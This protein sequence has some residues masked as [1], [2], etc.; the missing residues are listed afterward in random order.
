[1]KKIGIYCAYFLP[2][3]GG[4][5][6]YVD[7]LS[8]NLAKLGY[9]VVIITSNHDEL[10]SHE[11]LDANR[12]VYRLPTYTTAKDRYP[13]LRM[14]SVYR[15]L[16]KQIEAE[17]IDCYLINTRFYMLSYVGARMG[18]RAHK[19]VFL[20]EHG[21]DHF[22]VNNRWLDYFGV[23]YEHVLTQLLKPKINRYYGVSEKCNEWLE[24]FSIH[25][26]GVFYN[27]IDVDDAAKVKDYYKDVYPDQ[28]VI[29]YAGRLIKEKGVLNLL[30]AF[31]KVKKDLP[32]TQIKLVVAGSGDL[33]ETVRHKYNDPAIDVVGSLDFEHVM[34][35][36]KRT[37]IFIH[38]SLYPEGLP[39]SIL[40]AGLMQ[41]AVIATP[42]G[43][44]EEVITD[45]RYGII[46]DGSIESLRESIEELVTNSKKR[47]KLAE[48]IKH[49]VEHT[50]SWKIVAKEVDRAIE[51]F[52]AN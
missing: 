5:E 24:H 11:T 38:P 32:K 17:N 44:T 29:T 10:K 7:K 22:S 41:C 21:T 48:M 18:K 20:I 33:L 51:D 8:A 13:L 31:L 42:R 46:V 19:P 26:N 23:I 25:A 6:R 49:R 16:I 35:L 2:H 43:G 40:E 45:D 36:Y 27:A 14:N 15:Q 30:E 3:L 4:V 52:R 28:I 9:K 39:T 12:S 47:T 1:M 37:D 34:S 50:F